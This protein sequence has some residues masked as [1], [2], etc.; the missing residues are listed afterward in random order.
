MLLH[1]VPHD[2]GASHQVVIKGELMSVLTRA[3]Y[4]VGSLAVVTT[5][6]SRAR[7]LSGWES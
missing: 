4:E 6:Q 5:E 7:E 1:E 3:E 2:P